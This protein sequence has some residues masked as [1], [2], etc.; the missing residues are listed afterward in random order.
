MPCRFTVKNAC[1]IYFALASVFFMPNSSA[2]L[3]IAQ[4]PTAISNNA[5]SLIS[6]A[7]GHYRLYSFFGL[8]A[9]KT[10]QDVSRNAFEYQSKTK[11]WRQLASPPVLQGRLASLAVTVADDIYLFGGYTVNAKGEEV[12]TPDVLRFNTKTQHYLA[13]APIPV[14]VD[15]SVA[16]V[17]KNRWIILVSGWHEKDNVAFVQ[18]YSIKTNS[19]HRSTDWPGAPV[20]GHAAALQ[21]N[22]LLVCDGV[23]LHVNSAG[24]REFST[25]NQCWR[26]QLSGRER[27]HIQWTAIS[28][29]PGAARYRMGANAVNGR[30]YF[31]GGSENPYNYNGIGYNGEPSKASST[32]NVYN[33]AKNQWQEDQ[34]LP[35]ASMDHRALLCRKST[36]F[37]VGG[38]RNPQIVSA[39]TSQLQL[40]P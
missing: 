35:I 38:M 16:V 37:L 4:L 6:E 29:H 1:L 7:N 11:Q 5:T 9:G 32:I 30:A 40:K 39:S 25:S 33:F 15:D 2:Q 20:F 18:V 28:P 19:W 23:K 8:S 17:Y 31:A 34:T 36:C 27:L 26:G 3:P 12:S 24:K 10:W 21:H 14:P 13:L 22:A